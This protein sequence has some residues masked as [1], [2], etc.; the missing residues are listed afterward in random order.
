MTMTKHRRGSLTH[1]RASAKSK[2]SRMPVGSIAMVGQWINTGKYEAQVGGGMNYHERF[3]PV[4]QVVRTARGTRTVP[5]K[6]GNPCGTFIGTD[7][8]YQNP[9]WGWAIMKDIGQTDAQAKAATRK[10]L[11]AG[12]RLGRVERD[13]DQIQVHFQQKKNPMQNLSSAKAFGD[14][15]IRIE[16]SE[17]TAFLRGGGHVTKLARK[18]YA[19]EGAAKRAYKAITSEKKLAAWAARYGSKRKNPQATTKRLKKPSATAVTR[20]MKRVAVNPGRK[21]TAT[22]PSASAR[23]KQS[24]GPFYVNDDHGEILSSANY[25]RMWPG[26]RTPTPLQRRMLGWRKI[27]K[28]EA[29]KLVS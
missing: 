4:E 20:R 1:A 7:A 27:S 2:L 12:V 5:V 25:K 3:M 26:G 18:Y 19:S 17:L 28:A 11:G 10:H 23:I 13:F 21:S 22:G 14:H 8:D 9:A 15:S 16:G 6:R 29:L 24:K